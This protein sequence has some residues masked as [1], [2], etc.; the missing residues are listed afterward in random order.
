MKQSLKRVLRL[1]AIFSALVFS[2]KVVD[3]RAEDSSVWNA[4]QS[5]W[6]NCNYCIEYAIGNPGICPCRINEP[7]IVR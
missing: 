6:G 5:P 4:I 2:V 3:A 7:I 1:V